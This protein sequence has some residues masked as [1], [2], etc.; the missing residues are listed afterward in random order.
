VDT[1]R[2]ATEFPLLSAALKANIPV[3]GICRGMQALNVATGGTLIRDIPG[4]KSHREEGKEVA[5]YHRIFIAPGS[6]LAA[7]IGAGG[8]VRVN[9]LH[10]QAVR[11][12]QKSPN[13]L[14][15]AYSLDDGIIEAIESQYHDWVIGVQFQPERRKELP[16]QFE[17]LFQGLVYRSRPT[18]TNTL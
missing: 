1:K 15:S 4:H 8:F 12:P 5:S 10:H 17:R 3:L 2:D 16:R 9:S 18:K 14:A 13:M 11:E 6:K 7:I